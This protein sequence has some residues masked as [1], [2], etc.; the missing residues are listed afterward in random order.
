[1][2]HLPFNEVLFMQAEVL[3]LE[4]NAPVNEVEV[5]VVEVA[6]VVEVEAVADKRPT[7][8]HEQL[9]PLLFITSSHNTRNPVPN[10]TIAGLVSDPKNPND[11]PSALE[12]VHNLALSDNPEHRAEFVRLID[13]YEGEGLNSIKSLAEGGNNIP[14]LRQMQIQ[15]VCLTE[16]RIAQV[17]PETGKRRVRYRIVCGERR[18]LAMAYLYAK[19]GEKFDVV[20]ALV[21]RSTTDSARNIGIAENFLRRNPSPSEVAYTYL[22]LKQEG[23]KIADIAEMFYANNP[24]KTGSAAYQE[25][26]SMLKLVSGANKLSPERLAKLDNGDIGLTK[27]K[28]EAEGGQQAEPKQYERRRTVGIRQAE[29]LLDEAVVALDAADGDTAGIEGYIEACAA[30][31]QFGTVEEAVEQSRARLAARA[32]EVQVQPNEAA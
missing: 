25:V 5:E 13:D 12:L 6:P 27:A 29:C 4:Q 9:I 2:F 31:M 1:M 3:P 30:F 17:D 28:R 11:L 22:A 16:Y 18:I 32:A 26:R 14:G 24:R 23:M 19:Y 8:K 21:I 7:D 10:L 15:P 20:R